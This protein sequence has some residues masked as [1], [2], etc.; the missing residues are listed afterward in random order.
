[1]DATPSPAYL[2]PLPKLND[3][4]RPFW[5]GARAARLCMQRCGECRH[6]RFPISHVCPQCLSYDFDWADLS[7]RGSVFAYIVYHQLYNKAFAADL[8]Y[9][10][11]LVQLDEGPRMYSNV[12]G[13]RNDE[14]KVGDRLEVVFDPVTPEIT[15]PKFRLASIAKA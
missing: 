2:K 10:V 15:I 13:C 9:N 3:E 1:M 6:I 4:N 11:A 7:G 8:P 12:V 5:D 14:V